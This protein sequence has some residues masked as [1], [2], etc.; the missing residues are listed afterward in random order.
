MKNKLTWIEGETGDSAFGKVWVN[1]PVGAVVR[2]FLWDD[3]GYRFNKHNLKDVLSRYYDKL[4]ITKIEDEW[5]IDTT[6]LL[7][8]IPPPRP[9]WFT[10]SVVKVSPRLIEVQCYTEPDE[11]YYSIGVELNIMASD[12][13][14]KAEKYDAFVIHANEDKSVFVRPL[15]YTLKLMGYRIWF[16]E[17]EVKIGDSIRRTID[18]GLAI[19]DFGI[20]IIS[21]AFLKKEWPQYELNGLITREMVGKKVVLPVWF[22]VSFEEVLNY[23]PSIADKAA[24]TGTEGNI[25][26][27]A[28]IISETILAERNR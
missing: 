1:E 22:N 18:K 14:H 6:V 24:I 26:H 7:G 3:H 10:E 19:S 28:Q 8:L 13:P 20:A 12:F 16:D 2:V 25:E 15:V 17:F 5:L 23:S 11:W 4:L 21:K 27:V 9:T